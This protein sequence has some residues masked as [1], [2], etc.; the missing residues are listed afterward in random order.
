MSEKI[1]IPILEHESGL[2]AEQDFYYA[3]CPER[4][5]PGD[6]K[7]TAKSIPRVIGGIGPKSLARALEVYGTI[8]D[9]QLLP[10]QNIKE[11]EAVKMV[12]NAFRDLNIAFVNELA[13][14][15]EKEG[16]DVVNVING[17]A[18]KP[19]G[20]MAHYPGCGV[21]GHCIPVDPHYLINYG[22]QHGFRHN[23]LLTARQVNDY[24]PYHIIALLQQALKATKRQAPKV[25]VTV[26][27]LAYKKNI[28]DTRESP[29]IKILNELRYEGIDTVAY[30]PFVPQLSTVDSLAEALRNTDAVI[31]ATDH[32]A[33]RQLSPDDF[34][35]H[36]VP[37]VIDGR[38]CLPINDFNRA[39]FYFKS[40]GRV[41]HNKN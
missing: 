8:L 10:M 7:H 41:T 13:L 1:V 32:D 9:A 16:I 5:N 25:R 38:N 26:L 11:A 30:D 28:N 2:K 39:P 19:F 29:A 21:G 24:M 37:I 34:Q 35:A 18:T 14:A 23:L 22:L 12:E 31:I 6:Q 36:S 40:V 27:G 15:F 20:F 4:I 3:H 17:A 33:F